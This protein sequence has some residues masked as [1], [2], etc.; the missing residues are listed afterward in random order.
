[1]RSLAG[2]PVDVPD[3]HIII[4]RLVCKVHVPHSRYMMT[5]MLLRNYYAA[6]GGIIQMPTWAF[7][8]QGDLWPTWIH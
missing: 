4:A 2:E 7:L 5:L 1:M 6:Q 8:T 3:V